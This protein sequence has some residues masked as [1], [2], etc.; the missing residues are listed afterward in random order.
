MQVRILA[1][2]GAPA[3]VVTGL[4]EMMLLA[5][6]QSGSSGT[7]K[8]IGERR[9]VV[10]CSLGLE[11][12]VHETISASKIEDI[13]I[14]II[15]PLGRPP[16]HGFVF[17]EELVSWISQFENKKTIVGSVCTG[18]F[19]FAA[20]G[21][22]NG[23]KASTHWLFEEQF[24]SSFPEVELQSQD[25]VVE[26]GL[27]ISS[28]GA[29]AYQDMCLRLIERVFGRQISLRCARLLVVD[30]SRQ[31]QSEYSQYQR[32][33]RHKDDKI[34]DA[35]RWIEENYQTGIDVAGLADSACLSERHFKRRFKNATGDA[36][37]QYWQKIRIEKAKSELESTD[38]TVEKIG[39]EC[40][41]EDSRFFRT[42][43]KR[44]TNLT[45]IEYRKRYSVFGKRS[46]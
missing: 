28:G 38:K 41:Y 17:S 18:A 39:L 11:L 24:R 46:L 43:F 45:P 27:W 13:D 12:K 42:L 25:M 5:L 19:L 34:S 14:L 7:V 33:H 20:T 26:D 40:G 30:P 6:A 44:H 35:Q 23:R 31:H 1:V 15:G 8:I 22:L 16:E 3:S 4:Y 36:P 9:D 37:S 2:D 10:S 21:M 32:F 29:S